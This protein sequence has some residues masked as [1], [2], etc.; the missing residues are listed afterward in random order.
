MGKDLYQV[1][2]ECKDIRALWQPFLSWPL[3]ELNMLHY[4]LINHSVE[5]LAPVITI[6]WGIW[7]RHNR[8]IFSKI[9]SCI[10]LR[11]SIMP[12]HYSWNI[13]QQ[14]TW[15]WKK[16]RQTSLEATRDE[17]SKVK[18]RWCYLSN[19][20]SGWHWFACYVIKQVVSVWLPQSQK[21]IY[22]TL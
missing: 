3:L 15:N 4:S 9:N 21:Q 11:Q 18:H 8:K 17:E 20:W 16:S 13:R 1:L 2:F 7:F 5:G 19:T 22:E 6:A 14:R 12:S 10:W